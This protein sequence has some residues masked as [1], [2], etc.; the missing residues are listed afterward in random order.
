M[1]KLLKELGIN[2]PGEYAASGSYIV[3][4][5]DSNAFGKVYSLLDNSDLVY[6]LEDNDLIGEESVSVMY[7]NDEFL[8]NLIMDMDS[9]KYQLVV[10]RV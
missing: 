7:T 9:E 10:T 1:N 3:N 2:Y 4:I 8:L 6:N 5:P